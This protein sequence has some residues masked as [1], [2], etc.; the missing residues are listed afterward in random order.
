MPSLTQPP[1]PET[2]L[3]HSDIILFDGVCRLCSGWVFFVIHR[4]PKGQ[5]KF[6]S[7]QSPEGQALLRWLDLPT[8]TYDTMVYIHCGQSYYRSTAFLKIVPAFGWQWRWFAKVA[9]LVPLPIRDWL[10]NRI[11]L[12]RYGLFGKRRSCLLPTPD[13]QARFLNSSDLTVQGV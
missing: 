12:N 11:A 2:V 13:I 10:Y 8:E 5:F 9:W 7:V 1:M 3:R 4:D 6:A